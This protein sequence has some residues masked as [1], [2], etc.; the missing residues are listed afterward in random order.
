MKVNRPFCEKK[1]KYVKVI[2]CSKCTTCA[3]NG[4]CSS[5]KDHPIGHPDDYDVKYVKYM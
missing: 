1:Q 4:I 3:R 2:E 5:C